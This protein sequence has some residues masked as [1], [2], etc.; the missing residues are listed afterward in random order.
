MSFVVPLYSKGLKRHVE[1]AMLSYCKNTTICRRQS[2]FMTLT[3]LYMIQITR[4][5][6]VVIFVVSI[7][8]VVIVKAKNYFNNDNIL[9]V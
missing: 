6:V 3:V 1:E 5:A 9:I 8:V 7:V 2:Y 4:D